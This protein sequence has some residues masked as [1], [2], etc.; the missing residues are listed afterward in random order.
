MMRSIA[1]ALVCL[2]PLACASKTT[3][4]DGDLAKDATQES[5]LTGGTPQ[6]L[7]PIASGETKTVAY[8]NPPKYRAFGF[9]AAGGDKIT[10]DVKSTNYGDAMAWITTTGWKSIVSNDD[11]SAK[12]LDSHIEY[13]VPAGT[14]SKSYR[15]VFR[16]YDSLPASFDVSLSIESATPPTPPTPPAPACSPESEPWRNYVGTS[17]FQC[18][19][20]ILDCPADRKMF[21]NA[22]GCGCELLSH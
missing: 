6:Y 8:T 9:S 7:G 4:E 5:D 10:I 16:D 12:T 2:A 14:A 18:S 11:A 3:A 22:C 21:H 17:T 19:L 20:I 13:T 1:F 15:L